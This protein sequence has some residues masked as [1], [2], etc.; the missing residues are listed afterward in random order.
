MV[1]PDK[2]SPDKAGVAVAS[3][4]RLTWSRHIRYSPSAKKDALEIR[5][6][7]RKRSVRLF[8]YLIVMAQGGAK[9]EMYHNGVLFSSSYANRDYKILGIAEGWE[10]AVKLYAEM[11]EDVYKEDPGL[12]YAEY[13][14]AHS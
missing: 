9:P 7:I 12:D 1:S 3:P 2:V 11:I 13:F 14:A 4:V 5:R 8:T 6:D 10:E